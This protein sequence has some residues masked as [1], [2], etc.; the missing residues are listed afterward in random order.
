M[1]KNYAIIAATSL[2]HNSIIITRNLKDFQI[3]EGGECINPHTI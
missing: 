1:G 3:V 2:A